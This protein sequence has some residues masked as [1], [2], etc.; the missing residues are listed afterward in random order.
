M[1]TRHKLVVDVRARARAWCITDDAVGELNAATPADWDVVVAETETSSDGDGG[2]A[3][4]QAVLNAITDAEVY[5]GFGISRVLFNAAPKLRWVHTATAGIASL[6]FDE[7]MG[8]DVALTNSAKIYGPT[9]AEHVLGGVLFFLRSFD[10]A[11]EGQRQHRWEK[12]EM[13]GAASLMR[14][15]S[16]SHV[17]IV[18][19]GGIG[20]EIAMRMSAL[21]A[22]CTG[23]RRRE[24]LGAPPGFQRIRGWSTEALEE[25][26]PRADIVI[27]S[28]PFTR[29]TNG[30]LN[31]SRMAL[32]RNGAIVVN[33]AR[34]A[35]VDEQALAQALNSGRIRGA[36][37]DVV[38]GEPLDPQSPLWGQRGVFL[39][40]HV[41][42]V[43]PATFWKREMEL[44][45]ENWQR[46]R[47][48]Q[49]LRNLVDKQAGY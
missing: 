33:V 16:G 13:T 31:A 49:P 39:T 15:L 5:F 12:P 10:Q 47:S 21:G 22:V 34:G 32:L 44:F 23:I 25:E 14:E 41:A 36:F 19:A 4:P 28:A 3:P 1:T 24:S 40:P 27:L 6:L 43:A 48:G 18:G 35:L 46:Y 45:L 42:A 30:L 2:A 11:V 26:L 8:R 38:M 17:L 37:L 20:T 29:E 7:M 9:M